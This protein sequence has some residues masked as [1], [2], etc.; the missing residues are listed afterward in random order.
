MNPRPRNPWFC[1]LISTAVLVATMR[2]VQAQPGPLQNY[3]F[4]I[5]AGTTGAPTYTPFAVSYHPYQN[6]SPTDS[7]KHILTTQLVEGTSATADRVIDVT[8]GGYAYRSGGVWNGTLNLLRNKRAFMILNRHEQREIVLTGYPVDSVTYIS[9]MPEG[10]WRA[11]GPRMAGNKPVEAVGLITYGFHKTQNMRAGG[12]LI[13]DMVT[14]KIARCDSTDGWIGPLD[15]LYV[16]HPL[17]IQTVFPA[18]FDWTYA[19]GQP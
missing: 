15:S 8:A 2:W 1:V 7:V 4:T 3:D 11:I 17:I 5:A 18:T 9:P 12:D 19:P 10:E 16:G 14:R 13:I 6:G